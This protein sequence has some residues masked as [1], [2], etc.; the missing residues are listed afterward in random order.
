MEACSLFSGCGGDTLGMKKAGL[1]VSYFS[2]LKNTFQETHKLNFKK[3]KL[4]GGDIIKITDQEFQ[5][6]EGKI[7]VLFGGFPCQ[8]FSQ[9]GKKDPNDPRGQLYKQFVRAA[10]FIQPEYIIG[11]NVKGLM[12]RKTDTGENFIDVIVNAFKEIGYYCHYKVL[13]AEDFGVSQKRERLFIIGKKCETWTPNWPTPVKKK[14][15][16]K[17]ILEFDLT[18]AIEVSKELVDEAGV[19]DSAILKGSGEPTGKPHPYLIDRVNVDGVEY[20]GKTYSRFPFSFGKRISPV[21]CEIVDPEG[22]SKTIICT[23]GHQPRLFVALESDGKY[24]LRCLTITELKQIQ[25]F[26]KGYKLSGN[27][28][29]QVI[30]VGNAVPPPLVQAICK[31]L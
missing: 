11:E 26:P 6:L 23:Y 13:K 24:Y 20:K 22:T 30:Q 14:K 16:L 29:D 31:A 4:L 2:E 25:G 18:D 15:L 27:H 8:S 1:E 19:P 21:H 10:N 17:S 3:S 5:N 12:T 7:K 28:K 9:G